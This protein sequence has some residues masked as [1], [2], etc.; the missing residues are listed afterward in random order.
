[1]SLNVFK[2]LIA[3]SLGFAHLTLLFP[4]SPPFAMLLPELGKNIPVGQSRKAWLECPSCF[5]S[6][7][8]ASL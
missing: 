4:V 5:G 3:S 7:N 1:M 2:S 6:P 8:A